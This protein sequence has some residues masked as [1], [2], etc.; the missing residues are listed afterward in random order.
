MPTLIEIS[1][2]GEKLDTKIGNVEAARLKLYSITNSVPW[3][4]SA[5]DILARAVRNDA[6]SKKDKNRKSQ[7]NETAFKSS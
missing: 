3:K 6:F 5:E 2:Y 4:I 1:I 7:E